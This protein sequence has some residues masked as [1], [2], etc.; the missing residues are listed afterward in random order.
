MLERL[1]L[2]AKERAIFSFKK[3]SVMKNSMSVEKVQGEGDIEADRHYREATEKFVKSG[4]V[5]NA[6]TKSEPQTSEEADEMKQAE[7][8]GESK[9]K[10][11][12]PSS[13]RSPKRKS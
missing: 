3:V 12:D 13:P 5:A 10:G 9:S 4:K 1:F 2:K 6:V 11:E 8:L 7:R